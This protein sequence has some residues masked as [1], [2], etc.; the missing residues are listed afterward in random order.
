M[1]KGSPQQMDDLAQPSQGFVSLVSLSKLE[2]GIFHVLDHIIRPHRC[3]NL[4]YTESR[5]VLLLK[6][7]KFILENPAFGLLLPLLRMGLIN[8]YGSAL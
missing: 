1:H 7:K 3:R 4:K 6:K 2:P 8:I 5:T